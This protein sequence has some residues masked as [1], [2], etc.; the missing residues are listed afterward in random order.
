MQNP[1]NT[2]EN[3]VVKPYKE[4]EFDEFIKLI[5]KTNIENWG[6]MAEAL[7]VNRDTISRWKKHPL[8]QRAI[9]KAIRHNTEGME[10]AG[11]DDWRMWREKLRMLGLAEKKQLKY[12]V[13]N[14]DEI[15]QLIN[16][17]EVD[18]NRYELLGKWAQEE[19]EKQ[20]IPTSPRYT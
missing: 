20:G 3:Y 1:S 18:D 11:K 8:A 13:S 4:I 7:N 17:L 12:E 2:A 10:R 6:A 5:G 14:E 19:M 15:G 9:V 16:K